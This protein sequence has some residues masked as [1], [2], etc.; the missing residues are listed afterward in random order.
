MIKR[1][2]DLSLSLFLL[3]PLFPIFILI[4]VL[5]KLDS[6][7]PIFF[8]QK[9]IGLKGKEFYMIKFRSMKQNAEFEGDGLFCYGNDSRVTRIGRLLRRTSFDE[10]PQLI[11]IIKGEMSFVGPRPPVSYE[12]GNY[13]SFK[14]M[15]KRRF[16][17]KP[18]IVGLA[19]VSGRN[20]INWDQKIIFDNLYIDNYKR[21]GVLEDIRIILLSIFTVFSMSNINENKL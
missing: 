9:R 14:G 2:L 3:I 12:L 1:I 10:F 17:V 8:I 16:I 21:I 15:L 19:Q 11:N 5:I 6:E 18:G 20:E 7:G 4:S 13:F